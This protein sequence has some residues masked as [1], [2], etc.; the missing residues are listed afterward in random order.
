[1]NGRSWTVHYFERPKHALTI[2][3]GV[4]GQDVELCSKAAFSVSA[5]RNWC[6][7][8]HSGCPFRESY[9]DV[10]VVQPATSGIV[11]AVPRRLGVA[12][13]RHA[14]RT[15]EQDYCVEACGG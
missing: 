1:V 6:R 12:I 15:L 13:R 2:K 9:R 7:K 4:N 5:C 11:Q 8:R 14:A 10:L 3:P